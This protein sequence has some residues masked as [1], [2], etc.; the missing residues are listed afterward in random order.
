MFA[1]SWCRM[2]FSLLSLTTA[3]YLPTVDT[4]FIESINK[5]NNNLSNDI[6]SDKVYNFLLKGLCPYTKHQ[7]ASTS[8][9]T[10]VT[11][12]NIFSITHYHKI[13]YWSNS[14]DTEIYIKLKIHSSIP[15]YATVGKTSYH[16]YCH[17][18]NHQSI[19][20]T[21]DLRIIQWTLTSN[22]NP[23]RHIQEDKSKQKILISWQ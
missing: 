16:S 17:C 18:R 22:A 12:I 6:E 5:I 8:T 3:P 19:I 20:V 7:A 1:W 21:L 10:T 9:S 4:L 23:S 15:P 11:N 13:L 2:N 14:T